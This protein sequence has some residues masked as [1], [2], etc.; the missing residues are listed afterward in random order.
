MKLIKETLANYTSGSID[1]PTFIKYMYQEHHAH[2]FDY[3]HYLSN[4]NIKKIEI[5]D[6][7]V[8]MTSRDRGVRIACSEGDF[9]ISPIET[10]NFFDYER[11]ESMMM[12]NLI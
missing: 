3:A 11:P 1:K 7:S 9:R 2:L 5:E 10:L 8:T 6:G 4:T 12:E